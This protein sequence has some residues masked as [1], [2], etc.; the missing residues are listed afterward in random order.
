MPGCGPPGQRR[1]PGLYNRA[2]ASGAAPPPMYR[3]ERS[4]ENATEA[5]PAGEATA[6]GRPCPPF[7]ITGG[8]VSP[9]SP[10]YVART[11]DDEL[12]RALSAGEYCHILEAPQTGKTSLMLR[13]ARRLRDER[14]AAVAVLDLGRAGQNV[15]PEQ[16]YAGLLVS[17]G[18]QVGLEGELDTHWKSYQRFGPLRRFLSA[19]RQVALPRAPGGLFVF[20][21]GVEAVCSLPFSADEFFAGIRECHD[22]RAEDPEYDRLAFCLLGVAAPARLVPDPRLSPFA[23][24]R[25]VA[26]ADFTGDEAAPLAAGFGAPAGAGERLLRRVLHWTGGQPC[27]TQRLCRTASEAVTQA[28]AA[29]RPAPALV[30]RACTGLFLSGPGR[31]G[32]DHLAAVR[33]RLLSDPAHHAEDV[34]ELYAQVRAGRPVPDDESDPHCAILR[35]SGVARADPRTGD[36]VVRNRIYARVFDRGWARSVLP[37]AELRRQWLA[38][39]RTAARV[40]AVIAASVALL[41]AVLYST[42]QARER[43]RAAALAEHARR[44][45]AEERAVEAESQFERAAADAAALRARLPSYARHFEPALPPG[46][47]AARARV[48][49]AFATAGDWE[50]AATAYSAVL[51]LRPGDADARRGLAEALRHRRRPVETP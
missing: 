32:D 25:R 6:C 42:W 49:R 50:N 30:D 28:P 29:A 24:G 8:P 31:E 2:G 3:R 15:S 33:G 27:L 4:H 47:V 45:D 7:Y 1:R 38:T 5:P 51:R 20:V 13:T 34:L 26:L 17:L 21:D 39:Q 48:A 36:L 37:A 18:E 35:L 22:R 16:W 9:G 14:R 12:F 46:D 43:A 23:V 10:S 11:V 19:L 44:I 41:T 40:T